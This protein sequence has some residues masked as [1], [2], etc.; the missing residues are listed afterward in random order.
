M[1]ELNP[2]DR[3]SM[4]NIYN[5]KYIDVVKN[6]EYKRGKELHEK[7]KQPNITG[8]IPQ[9][10]YALLKPNSNRQNGDNEYISRLTGETIAINDMKHN[11]MQPY[12]RGGVT[13]NTNL[14]KF[15][16]KLDMDTGIDKFYIQKKE[17]ERSSFFKPSSIVENIYGNKNQNDFLKNRMHIS[18]INNNI[19][20]MDKINVGPGLNKGYTSEGSGGFQQNDTMDYARPKTLDQLRSKVNQRDSYFK[21]PVKAHIKGTDQV[22]VVAPYAKNKPERTY[23]QT[24]DNWFKTT[25]AILKNTERPEL[26]IK[27]TGRP[28]LH[29]DYQGGVKYGNI[30]GMAEYDD[31]GKQ[32]V[33]VY[34]NERQATQSCTVVANL[35]T[36][37]KAMLIPVIDALKLSLKEYLVES[38]RA[39]GNPQAQIPNKPTAYDPSD[40]PKITVKETVL[41]DSENLNLTGPNETYS[42]LH[43]EAKTTVKETLIHDSDILN[44][45]P[46]NT[47]MYVQN[48]DDAKKTQRETLPLID[49]KRNIGVTVY[50]V[51]LYNPDLAAK[52][53]VKE[54]TIKGSAELGFISGIINK[55]I[56]GYATKEIDI[57]NTHKQFTSDNDQYGIAKSVYIHRQRSREAEENAEINGARER[58]LIEAGHTPN[59]GNMN[60]PIDKSNIVMG[61]KRLISDDYS[62]RDAGNLNKVYQIPAIIKEE[63]ITKDTV[64]ENAFA[65][66]LDPSLLSGLKTNDLSIKINPI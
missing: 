57:R 48:G 12:L 40:T 3:P 56:G 65:D 35:T 47:C 14:E 28:D 5:S 36:N 53:T 9:P 7:S 55:L 30:Q 8:V 34:D 27:T 32:N 25:G 44:V 1:M 66:R 18:K 2:A 64:R 43:D 16:A 51:Y 49:T 45:K 31:Y 60:I 11:N 52:T 50:K 6:N 54:T 15:S 21:I 20:P 23:N 10:A 4:N 38:A 62:E 59:A 63:N 26:A 33:L 46:D 24:E 37:V 58:L 19:A 42:A 13:Q 41:H 17:V 22:G 39:G 61:S 29:K